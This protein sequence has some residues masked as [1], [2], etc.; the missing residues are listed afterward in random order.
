MLFKNAGKR[1]TVIGMK[2]KSST[3]ESWV[4]CRENVSRCSNQRYNEKC[5]ELRRPCFVDEKG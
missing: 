4:F 2:D 1:R 3:K 5:S